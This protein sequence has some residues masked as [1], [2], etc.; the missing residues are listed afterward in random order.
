MIACMHLFIGSH[1]ARCSD[2]ELIDS[3]ASKTDA[4]L[5]KLEDQFD[6]I[7]L[8]QVQIPGCASG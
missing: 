8:N 7:Y 4:E 6:S 2:V 3:F 1:A 5:D